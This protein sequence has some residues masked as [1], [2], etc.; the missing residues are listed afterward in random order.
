MGIKIPMQVENSEEIICTANHNNKKLQT[1]VMS[2]NNELNWFHSA[3]FGSVTWFN[4]DAVIY[5]A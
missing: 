1:E 4:D 5:C 3:S 2:E